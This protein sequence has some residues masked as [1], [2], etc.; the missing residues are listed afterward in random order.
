MWE[1]VANINEANNSRKLRCMQIAIF[2]MGGGYKWD[3]Q[4]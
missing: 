2:F 1:I 3:V 4:L